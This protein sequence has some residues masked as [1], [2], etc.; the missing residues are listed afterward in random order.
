MQE[1]REKIQSCYSITKTMKMKFHQ[2]KS[3]VKRIQERLKKHTKEQDEI[4]QE[5]KTE[6]EKLTDR[7]RE[8]EPFQTSHNQQKHRITKLQVSIGCASI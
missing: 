4:K 2:Q 5:M 8:L 3:F 7:V 1:M 6:N